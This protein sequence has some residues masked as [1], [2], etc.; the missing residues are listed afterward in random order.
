MTKGIVTFKPRQ[1]TK[2]LL[3]V[4]SHRAQDIL[5]K[6]YGLG[7]L[8]DRMTLESIGK[9]YGITRERVR[10]IE[11][12]A[13]SSIRR[14]AAFGNAQPV[15][16]ELKTVMQEYGTVVKEKDFLEYLSQDPSYQNHI[17]FLLVLGDYFEKLREDDQFHHRWTVD[18]NVSDKIERSIISLYKELSDD[19]LVLEGDMLAR[20]LGH[21]KKDLKHVEDIILAR[22]WLMLSKLV[23][24][25]PLGE[26]GRANSPNVRARG[27]RDLAY[28][29]LRNHGSPMHFREVALAIGKKFNKKAHEATVHNELIKD[30]RFILVG[31]GLYA[32]SEW[33]Y[34][35]GVVREVIRQ[36]LTREGPLT[37]N[38]LIEK[39]MKE[40]HVK[41]NT[42]LVNLQNS[43][44]FRKD[45]KGRYAPV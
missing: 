5:K 40:R 23:N 3:S 24:V 16:D 30:K 43:K 15:F 27:I 19:E 6:R 17:H 14:A 13:I 8:S 41:E 36:I 35:R 12:F 2:T 7:D 45:K 11:N 32:L 26:W 44:Y 34:E 4:L 37:K 29:V 20:F 10:Q 22:R 38:E 31:R 18:K 28:L 9:E 42:V 1:V 39:V 33:G 25:N 21:I